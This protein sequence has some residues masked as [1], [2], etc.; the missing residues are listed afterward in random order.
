MRVVKQNLLQDGEEGQL[1]K[2]PVEGGQLRATG[3][4]HPTHQAIDDHHHG[5]GDEHLV[6]EDCLHRLPQLYRIDLEE[7]TSQNQIHMAALQLYNTK[8]TFSC[9]R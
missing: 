9:L 4:S 3:V 1:R 2:A 8:N 7:E 6:E 5:S